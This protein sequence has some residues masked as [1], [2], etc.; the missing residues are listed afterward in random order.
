MQNAQTVEIPTITASE[1][2]KSVHKYTV[3]IHKCM[4]KH[5]EN[6]YKSLHNYT[7]VG[8]PSTPPRH[9]QREGR[10]KKRKGRKAAL[11]VY[12]FLLYIR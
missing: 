5:R 10:E 8:T 1:A 11:S 6:T 9:I 7:T 4:Q 12:H 3:I 2:V